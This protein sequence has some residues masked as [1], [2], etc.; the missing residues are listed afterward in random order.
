MKTL[1]LLILMSVELVF[2]EYR[3]PGDSELKIHWRSY[4][5]SNS[6]RFHETDDRRRFAIFKENYL[7]VL[8]HNYANELNGTGYTT[9]IN[10]FSYL[11][12]DEFVKT[13]LS[14]TLDINQT[15]NGLLSYP[16]LD[17]VDDTQSQG[18]SS[19]EASD[20]L[21]D[22]VNWIAKNAVSPVK[23]QYSCG[24]CWSF[25]AIGVVESLYAIQY[26][27]FK[28]FSE[29]NLIDCTLNAYNP[30]TRKTNL[31]CNGGWP[32]TAFDYI[33]TNGVVEESHY[34]YR[35]KEGTCQSSAL[36]NRPKVKISGYRNIGYGDELT[37]KKA[38]AKIGPVAV[39]IDAGQPGFSSYSSGIYRSSTCVSSRVNHAVIVVGYGTEYGRDYWLVK[40]SWGTNWGMNGFIKMARN[41][42]NMCG[43]VSLATYAY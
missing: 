37:L 35:Q 33:K 15:Q 8:A 40:N 7:K 4:K 21:P 43:I 12:H 14:M 36:A 29:Q 2:S 41:Q 1:A 3:R 27:N 28:R 9:E 30:N 17:E 11:S 25:S 20:D 38:V 39:G 16:E 32:E 34:P 23:N 26:K 5:L 18:L 19:L 6:L 10:Q 24:S 42:N 31:G 13:R 22:T